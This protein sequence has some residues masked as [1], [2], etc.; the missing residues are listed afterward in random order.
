VQGKVWPCTAN[1]TLKQEVM[2]KSNTDITLAISE[3][4]TAGGGLTPE[5][6]FQHNLSPFVVT[7]TTQHPRKRPQN[8]QK[9]PKP[10]NSSL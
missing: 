7:K 9:H 4:T 5:S 6:T 2:L 10:F 3:P 8:T 1:K